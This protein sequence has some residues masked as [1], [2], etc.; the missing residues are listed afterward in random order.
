MTDLLLGGALML[1]PA[2]FSDGS[3]ASAFDQVVVRSMGSMMCIVGLALVF[4]RLD[5][6]RYWPF[7]AV[8]M[9]GKL[10]GLAALLY[11]SL[12]GGGGELTAL[13]PMGLRAL[14]VVPLGYVLADIFA[15]NRRDG[16]EL[17]NLDPRVVSDCLDMA[18]TQRGETISEI[19]DRQPVMLLMLRHVGCTF[20]REALSDL[21]QHR[22]AIEKM[23]VRIVLVH[24]S[25]ELDTAEICEH[26]GVN[27]IDRIPD[28]DA[29]LY[30]ALGVGRGSFNALF[31]PRVW[32]RGLW[33]GV[34]DGHGIG[35]LA[36]DPMRLSA[37][38]MIDRGRV[39]A[40]HR[41]RSAAERPD[42]V[43]FVRRALFRPA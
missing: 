34:V 33:A 14:W 12:V 39:L 41:H 38:F 19:A 9:A 36:G 11:F 24:M 6:R 10:P 43:G 28:P 2:L 40:A 27:D 18:T 30:R 26:Y 37:L 3:H 8:G 42:Y 16:G 22:E 23:G 25:S 4:A 1:A 5:P 35:A 17:R 32:L 13:W 7:V 20:C 29:E 15:Q 31:G 21:R